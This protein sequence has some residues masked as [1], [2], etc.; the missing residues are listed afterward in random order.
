[1]VKFIHRLSVLV[2]V[3]TYRILALDK[4]RLLAKSNRFAIPA[5]K[6]C[7]VKKEMLHLVAL[8]VVLVALMKNPKSESQEEND[9]LQEN[10]NVHYMMGQRLKAKVK[11]L[12]MK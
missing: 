9:S 7:A 2:K 4:Y 5:L 8:V 6:K 11:D 10:P 3:N 12:C 1:M